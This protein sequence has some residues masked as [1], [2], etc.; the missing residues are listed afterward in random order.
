MVAVSDLSGSGGAERQFSDLY[1]HLSRTDPSRVSLIT[2]RASL[3]KLQAA[4][5]L[6]NLAGVVPLELGDRPAQTRAGIAWMT[7]KLL[8]TTIGR[9]YDVVHVCLPTPTYVP[10]A[11]LLT[12]LPRW[13]RPRISL[14]VVDCTLAHNLRAGAAADP[15]EQQVVDAHRMY[16]QWTRLDGVFTWYRAFAETV[17]ALRFFSPRTRV[18][19]ARY[20]FTD[21]D[22]F[23]PAT[24]KSNIII[25]AG[26]FSSQTRPLLFVDAIASFRERYPERAAG[27]RIHMFGGGPLEGEVRA[28]IAE[29]GLDGVIVLD[30]KPDL[31]AEFA[32]SRLFISTQAFEN[33]TS[34]ALLEAMA[35]GNGVIAA[36]VG[37]TRE[38]VRHGENGYVVPEESAAAFADAIAQYVADPAAQARMSEASRVMATR[39]HTIDHFAGDINAFWREVAA[40]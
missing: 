22:R 10:Y 25:F 37:Q 2:A 21:P 24:T 18:I 40:D 5:R 6:R 34:L 14:T 30:R 28:R 13:C 31:S 11:A 7:L 17:G 38:F 26:R 1:E 15:Y 35:A 16:S 8:W 39:V 32:G 27:W 20:C 12:A 36:D 23:R 29:H 3:G 19:A 9:G 33:F 4:G